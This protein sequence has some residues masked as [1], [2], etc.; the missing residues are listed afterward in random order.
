MIL[1]HVTFTRSVKLIRKRGLLTFQTTNW[2]K[3]VDGSRYSGGEIYACD[4]ELDA[5]RW[6]GKMDWDHFK[7]TGSGRIS[8]VGFKAHEEFWEKDESDPLSQAA[9]EGRWL[10]S[11]KSVAPECIL[12]ARAFDRN[13]ARWL[14]ERWCR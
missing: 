13:A 5:L 3:R 14:V 8:L 7:Q 2:I 10:K 1:W 6:A 12:G 9:N 4:S 11:R